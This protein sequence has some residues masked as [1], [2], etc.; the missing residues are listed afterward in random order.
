MTFWNLLAIKCLHKFWRVRYFYA[1][2]LS[3]NF[4]LIG[5]ITSGLTQKQT[6]IIR[7][8]QP[9]TQMQ[10]GQIVTQQQVLVRNP[11]GNK[12]MGVLPQGQNSGVHQP[13]IRQIPAPTQTRQGK[14]NT[15]F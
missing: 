9:R 2:I 11:N 7:A 15:Y 8:A 13:V 3:L 6:L 14:N 4:R 12:I 5:L 10:S 1:T